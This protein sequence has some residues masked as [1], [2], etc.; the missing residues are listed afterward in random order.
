MNG[1]PLLEGTVDTRDADIEK[2]EDDNRDLRR[3][4]REANAAAAGAQRQST[5]AVGELRRQLTP[6]YEALRAVFG[7][8]DSVAPGEA[9]GPAVDGKK[10]GVWE[11]WISKLGGKQAECIK[12]LLEH[13]EMTVVQLRV[14]TH[15]GQQTVYDA[16]S[17]LNKLGLINKNNGRY[18]LREL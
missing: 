5:R 14:A 15:S 1:Q 16:T 2:L 13:G 9:E 10:R 11:S 8:M 12:A 7:E 17:K 4:L 18:S 3:Q 6:L